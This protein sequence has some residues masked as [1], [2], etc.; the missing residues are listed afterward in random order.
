MFWNIADE[1]EV[2]PGTERELWLTRELYSE[3]GLGV[4][5]EEG[6]RL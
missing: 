2:V 6:P 1:G 4:V 5:S 3:M